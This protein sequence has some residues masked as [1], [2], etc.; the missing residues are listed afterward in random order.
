M[1]SPNRNCNWI[2][3]PAGGT[4][5]SRRREGGLLIWFMLAYINPSI[6]NMTERLQQLDV[7]IENAENSI[8]FSVRLGHWL[9]LTVREQRGKDSRN[10]TAQ[11]RAASS[12]LESSWSCVLLVQQ[13]KRLTEE[14][15]RRGAKTKSRLKLNQKRV[16]HGHLEQSWP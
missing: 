11:H 13:S 9:I 5:D 7:L 8:R 15:H 10:L 3:R 6:W 2:L 4:A 16:E 14:T 1:F 12:T